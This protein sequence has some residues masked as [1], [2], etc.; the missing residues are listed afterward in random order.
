MGESP[1]SQAD[2]T[3]PS[4]ISQAANAQENG[5]ELMNELSKGV[6]GAITSSISSDNALKNALKGMKM[7]IDINIKFDEDK[8]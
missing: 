7:H 8:L 3:K 2:F 6:S 4:E 1:S 5:K